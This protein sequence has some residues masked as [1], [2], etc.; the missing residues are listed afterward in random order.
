[1]TVTTPPLP[2]SAAAPVDR[3]RLSADQVRAPYADAVSRLA[4]YDWQ[5]LHVPAH[6]RDPRNVP[7]LT[8]LVGEKALSLEFPMLFSQIDQETWTLVSPGRKTPLMQAQDLASEL[9]GASR[10]WF[11]TN[12]GSGCNHIATTVARALGR[13]SIVQRSVHSSVIDG[14]AHVGI[15]AHFVQ[16]SVDL[17]LGAA[18][19]VT[20]A[21]VEAA[22]DAHPDT[23]SVFLVS[24]SYFGAVSDIAGIAA[25]AHAHGIPL[26]VDEA[27]GS[28]FG[29]HDD[30]P[31]NAI[32][33]GADLVISSVQKTSGSL[34]QTAMLHLGTGPHAQEMEAL[35]DRVVRSYQST[36]CSPILLASLDVARQHLARH[37]DAAIGRA[38]DSAAR[39][40][41]ALADSAR[42]RDATADVRAMP[43][44]VTHDPLKI[45]IDLRGSGIGGND[46]H[47]VLLRE[48]RIY[49]ELSTPTA[50]LPLIP[51]VS[52]ADVER[53][54]TALESLP[55]RETG[56]SAPLPLPS[57]CVSAMPLSE[58]FYA[59]VELVP[60]REAAGRISADSLAA[61][62]PGVPNVLPGEVLSHEVIAYLRDTAAA[63][64]GYVRGA[65]DP[66]LETFRVVAR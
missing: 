36:S 3:S 8:S 1:M 32:R 2:A 24:P 44:A 62:P 23:A 64:S 18:H 66:A 51:A 16:G 37:G 61:Y 48:H 30:L 52:E 35:V 28:H 43:D 4:E 42:F 45:P 26:I 21:Q 38:L 13:E 20:A 33:L 6:N 63:A 7:A 29:L 60:H 49:V 54:M 47:N 39:L 12:G 59:P 17:G 5:H 19:G 31:I 27:W 22:L 46:A 53:F 34:A 65:V 11:L 41:S 56:A 58:A 40:R 50:L 55:V 9:W 14:L 57:P 25:V 10:T 15:D